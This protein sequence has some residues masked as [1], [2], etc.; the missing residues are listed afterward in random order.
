M[1]RTSWTKFLDEHP[2]RHIVVADVDAR[3]DG[4]RLRFRLS[5]GRNL[6]GRLI[7]GHKPK[8]TYAFDLQSNG[9]KGTIVCGFSAKA[10]ADRLVEAV[11]AK[12]IGRGSGWAS[13]RVFNLDD[14][15]RAALVEVLG[16]PMASA[17]AGQRRPRQRQAPDRP[18][19]EVESK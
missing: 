10:D 11:R 12:D 1:P 13:R 2:G 15:L 7:R 6:L 5:T 4:P 17:K 8:G 9:G 16:R 19:Q 18:L 14:A 3:D